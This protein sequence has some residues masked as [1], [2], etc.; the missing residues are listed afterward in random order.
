MT[1]K[2]TDSLEKALAELASLV[3]VE[4][5][6]ISELPYI[7]WLAQI[8]FLLLLWASLRIY[9]IDPYVE[10]DDGKGGDS[11]GS[12]IKIIQLEN[13]HKIYDCGY[14]LST[15]PGE[16]YNS[17]C[18]SK[19]INATQ[20]MVAML[21]SRGARQVAFAGHEIA[22]FA[23]WIECAENNIEVTNF[24]PN[25]VDEKKRERI[26][27]LREETRRKKVMEIGQRPS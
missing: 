3:P 10:T 9:Q 13:S 18:T 6:N 5:S 27:K 7:N 2:I 24:H 25:D 19:L 8:P 15:S 26:R 11:S 1:N 4:T 17:Y 20:K 14:F 16:E 12:D 22:Q 23:A 21:V